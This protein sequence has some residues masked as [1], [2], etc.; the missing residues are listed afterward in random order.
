MLHSL[1]MI[2]HGIRAGFSDFVRPGEPNQTG[3]RTDRD[4]SMKFV[5]GGVVLLLTAILL[6]ESKARF[7]GIGFQ[8]VAE[9][10]SP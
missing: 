1:P 6:P 10:T 3:L 8:W 2:W 9:G 7:D 4:L 5:A